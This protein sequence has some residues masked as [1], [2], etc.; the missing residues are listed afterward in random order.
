MNVLIT[1][2]AGYIGSHVVKQLIE[3]TGSNITILDNL[4]TGSIKA[5]KTLME[6][7]KESGKNTELQFIEA[8]LK[9]FQIVEGIFKAKKFD[10]VIHFAASIVVPESVRNPIKY[11][12]NNT[13]NTTNLINLC[14]KY[15]VNKF[16]FSSTA[17]VYGQP[18]EIPVKETTPTNPINPYGM[19]KLM[20][21]TV[22][23]D[24]G[25]AHP[26]FK[27]VILRYFNVA[28]ADAKIKVGQRFPNATHLI[29][30]AAE[31][32]VGKRDKIYIYGTDYPTPDG[33]CIR[34]YIHV[35]DLAD[36]HIRSL[37]YLAKNDSDIFNCGYGKGYSVLE[38]INT[39]KEVSGV[40]FKVE[41]TG[42][43]EGDPAILIADNTK[44]LNSLNWRPK[45]NDLKF[46]CK[47]ALEWEKKL[48]QEEV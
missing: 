42:R 18:E 7:H 10:A 5:V 12:M 36:A 21:E 16:I 44:I 9:D 27:Y 45:Y 23:K 2:G 41:Y 24:V 48:L 34:D 13:V 22:L 19:S 31:T 14:I 39:M 43:R 47:T 33:T 1:G 29:K 28:G 26:E 4:S 46:I 11:Y 20:S 8:D 37:E 6:I 17:A 25:S 3:N 30:V 35:D 40:D 15:G 32:A 38:V